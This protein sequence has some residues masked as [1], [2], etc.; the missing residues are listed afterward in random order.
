MPDN[1]P[2]PMPPSAKQSM[3]PEAVPPQAPTALNRRRFSVV[4]I[5]LLAVSVVILLTVAIAVALGFAR[6][7]SEESEGTAAA[8]N[9]P[10]EDL[11][12][13]VDTGVDGEAAPAPMADPVEVS[14]TDV[15]L[16]DGVVSSQCFDYQVP[17]YGEHELNRASSAC[18]SSIRLA[19]GDSL[20]EINVNAQVNTGSLDEL[21]ADVNE[22]LVGSGLE[23]NARIDTVAGR[24]WVVADAVDNYG[25]PMA[26]YETDITD[27]GLVYEGDPLTSIFISGHNGD[28]AVADELLDLVESID[29]AGL[30]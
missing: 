5:V 27:A 24:E 22:F 20:S 15:T 29:I 10:T 7:G 21:A 16:I 3:D 11:E 26:I 6:S 4:A 2:P 17:T 14:G 25:L 12:T 8:P 30:D 18:A 23:E 1:V 9:Q 13:E 19:G 28:P